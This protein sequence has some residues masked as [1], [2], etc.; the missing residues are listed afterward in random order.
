MTA[1]PTVAVERL[2]I[3]MYVMLDLGW[4]DHPFPFNH[5]KLRSRQQIDTLRSLG[6]KEVRYDPSRSDV[7]PLPANEPAPAVTTAP[8]ATDLEPAL[9]AKR[10]RVERLQAQRAA[11]QATEKALFSA[12]GTVRNLTRNLLSRPSET[13]KEADALIGQ[14]VDTLLSN[15]DATLH[16][17]G[18]KVQGEEI[19]FHSLNVAVLSMMIARSEDRP[20]VEIHTLGM[21]ALFHDIGK[22]EVPDRVQLKT[23]PLTR[24]ERDL[25]EQH[26]EFGLRIGKQAGLPLTVLELIAQHHEFADGSGYPRGLKAT[27]IHPLAAILALINRY[28]NLCN[29]LDL[30]QAQTPHETLSLL[31][32][33]ERTR[34]AAEPLN[35]LV[36]SLGVYPPGTVVKLSNDAYGMVMSVNRSKP[37]K[38]SIVIYDAAVP[39]E[40]AIILD[41]DQEPDVNISRAIRPAQ[42]PREVF[43]Y[44]SPRKRITY[45]LEP[46][47]APPGGAG[48]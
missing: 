16:L 19:Y 13:L 2:Q 45:F 18:D 6:L 11:I 40:E 42:L 14:L 8:V 35:T 36:R 12:A 20:D 46:G 39:K 5:F 1:F 44:L 17:M 10:Q 37:L 33:R 7:T 24:A 4:M 32:S 3:G 34:Y 43:S 47:E 25:M 31:F 23:D 48:L 38:P 22:I 26:V 21:A 27:Q 30:N 41:L 28:D 15:T 29:P 9:E